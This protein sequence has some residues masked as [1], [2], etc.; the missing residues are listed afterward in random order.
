MRNG[1]CFLALLGVQ[2]GGRIEK[3]LDARESLLDR[4]LMRPIAR[5]D[6]DVG[7]GVDRITL[8]QKRPQGLLGVAALQKGTMRAFAQPAPEN[9]L[10][11]FKPNRYSRQGDPGPCLLVHE[12]AAA[13]RK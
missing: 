9:V 3:T 6:G 1:F 5:N 4:E 10:I 8:F 13:T 12:G 2:G 11:R 7:Q